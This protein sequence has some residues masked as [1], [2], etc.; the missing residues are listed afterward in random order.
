[1]AKEKLMHK[2]IELRKLGKT[3][4]EILEEIPVAKSTLTL[5]LREVG[6]GIRQKQRIT[7][8]R[9]EGQKRGAAAQKSKRI[10]KQTFL[11]ENSQKEIGFISHRELWLIGVALYWAE[12]AKQKEYR[13]TSRTS[14]S[15]SDPKMVALFIKWAIEYLKIK[16]EDF[17]LSLYVH[18]SHKN[19]VDEIKK[20]WSHSL[21]LP[22]AFF[23]NVYFKRNKISTKRKNTGILY[24]GLLRV[25]IRASTDLNRKITGWIKGICTH[26]GL[27]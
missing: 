15:N 6:L 14:F 5:W 13:P 17:I 9:I 3:Y 2:A 25:N 22:F 16:K 19:R 1:M 26:C 21:K 8:K 7:Q 4:S 27:V 23:D 24:Y 20:F 12:G 10:K 18:E 11:I